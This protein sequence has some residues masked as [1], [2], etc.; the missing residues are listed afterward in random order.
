MYRE[1][2]TCGIYKIHH[3]DTGKSYVGLSVDIFR[4]WKEHS[5]F[6]EA[7]NKWSA[8]KH[9]LNKHG[10]EN[11]TFTIL[12]ECSKE[13]L[14]DREIH[15]IKELNTQAPNGYNLTAGGGSP[16][17]SEK[18]RGAGR[19]AS[20]EQ[21]VAV[22]KGMKE[23]NIKR[24]DETKRKMGKAKEKACV[25]NDVE[26]Q[27]VNDAIDALGFKQQNLSRYLKGDRKWPAGYN[28]YYK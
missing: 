18:G 9:A 5:N 15:W 8:I 14:N 6:W 10:L 27:S 28:G 26:Y 2:P 21:K 25:I 16:P 3:K 13:E 11:F 19:K 17:P 24:S 1:K 20:D 4:R 7:K 12:E 23:A 22:S